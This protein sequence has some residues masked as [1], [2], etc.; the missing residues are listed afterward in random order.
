MLMA[1]V[2]GTSA[3]LFSTAAMEAPPQPFKEL[4]L[5]TVTLY[6]YEPCPY[7]CKV[8]AVLDYLSIPYNVVE[9]NPLTKQE[10]KTITDY[11][12]V[13]VCVINDEV[14]VESSVIISRLHELV[15]A[16]QESTANGGIDAEE[17]DKWR[18][19]IDKKLV[20]N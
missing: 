20:S 11:K 1:C 14:V 4:S 19:W 10:T 13:P 12:K 7:C 2:G 17:E 8:K 16:N 6:Q 9:V 15:A 3:A 18:E 5:P